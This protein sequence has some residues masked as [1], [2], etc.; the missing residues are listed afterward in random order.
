MAL[1]EQNQLLQEQL[2][3]AT[4]GIA[5][6]NTNN[7]SNQDKMVCKFCGSRSQIVPWEDDSSSQ[8][9]S[10][11]GEMRAQYYFYQQDFEQALHASSGLSS[12][13]LQS[14][15]S[16]PRDGDSTALEA[17]IPSTND[18]M[19][20]KNKPLSLCSEE[21]TLH[22][23]LPIVEDISVP[24]KRD[25][26][27]ESKSLESTSPEALPPEEVY[28]PF[29]PG[30]GKSTIMCYLCPGQML[31]R[32]QVHPIPGFDPKT[33]KEVLCTIWKSRTG[34]FQNVLDTIPRETLNQAKC[35]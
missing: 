19:A 3:Q 4:S 21:G 6:S 15:N 17:P 35:Q 31:E 14:Y 11:N 30:S 26:S 1:A 2:G 29:P 34:T 7:N 16:A 22:H 24:C 10:D 20:N 25:D 28:V 18:N 5:R 33:Q 23:Q 9:I 32:D 13:T 8:A 27:Q 12:T